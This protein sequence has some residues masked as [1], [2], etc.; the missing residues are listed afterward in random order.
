[1]SRQNSKPLSSV[2]AV[3]S[4]KS[5]MSQIC[6]KFL[7]ASQ[8]EARTLVI[9]FYNCF[10]HITRL[11]WVILPD[12]KKQVNRE[13]HFEQ[14]YRITASNT[15]VTQCTRS[16][17]KKLV[18]FNTEGNSPSLVGLEGS[19]SCSYKSWLH[20]IWSAIFLMRAKNSISIRARR[21]NCWKRFYELLAHN[22]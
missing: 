10:S 12:Q 15:R 8:I 13:T 7:M 21:V 6:F 16:I 1:M 22:K 11:L 3:S 5:N 4:R 2:A 17:L 14:H 19:L 18:A 9:L 20:Q